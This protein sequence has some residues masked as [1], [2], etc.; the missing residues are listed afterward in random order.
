MVNI[1][2]DEVAEPEGKNCFSIIFRG[3]IK[4]YKITDRN[5]KTKMQ[6]LVCIHLRSLSFNDKLTCTSIVNHFILIDFSSKT[7]QRNTTK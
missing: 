3:E 4:D 1:H 5:I 7:N 6:L 2:R